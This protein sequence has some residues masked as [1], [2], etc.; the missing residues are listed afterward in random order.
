MSLPSAGSKYPCLEHI[1]MAP[2]T[3]GSLKFDFIYHNYSP[4]S[5]ARTSL[6]PW[7]FILDMG[8]TSHWE[9]IIVLCRKQ[10]GII[11]S[12]LSLS[13][14]PRDS[15]KHFE[16]SVVRH[17]RFTELRKKQLIEQPPLTEWIRNLTPKLEIYWKYC[18]K[19]E[20]LLLRSNFSSFSQYFIDCW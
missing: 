17:I 10:T 15:M 18:G 13:R 11:Y 2:K 6:G 1:P 5:M 12:R 14:T 8:S 7:K 9:L 4:T 16:I 3:F 20:K 19:E